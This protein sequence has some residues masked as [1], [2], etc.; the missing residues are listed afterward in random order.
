MQTNKQQNWLD[1]YSGLMPLVSNPGTGTYD[2]GFLSVPVSSP[3]WYA[4]LCGKGYCPSLLENLGGVG[5][6]VFESCFPCSDG[7]SGV[8]RISEEIIRLACE[9]SLV[10]SAHEAGCN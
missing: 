1:E 4:E 7:P 8:G 6:G 3:G 9:H 10:P 5:L 2:R